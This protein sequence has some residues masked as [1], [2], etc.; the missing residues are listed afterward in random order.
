MLCLGRLLSNIYIYYI[1]L[2]LK[3]KDDYF[4]LRKKVKSL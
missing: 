4:N 1:S 2:E 3:I